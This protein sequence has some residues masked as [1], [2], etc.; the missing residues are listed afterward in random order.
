MS[1]HHTPVE[2]ILDPI[3]QR[4]YGFAATEEY[5]DKPQADV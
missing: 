1:V 3:A 4:W 2:A 5:D